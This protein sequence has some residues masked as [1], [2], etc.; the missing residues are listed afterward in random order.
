MLKKL[1][2][3]I[4]NKKS[5]SFKLIA[6][7][8]IATI[9]A[10]ALGFVRE[11][12]IA[13]KYGTSIYSDAFIASFSLP[14]LLVSGFG[15]AIS[16]L[17][18]PLYLKTI[19][20]N[21]VEGKKFN[22]TVSLL[23]MFIASILV[24]AFSIF[25][26]FFTKLFVSGFDDE[27]MK[28][29]VSLSR[30]MIFASFPMLLSQHYKAFS[31]IKKKYAWSMLFECI[32]NIIIIT[33]IFV[34]KEEWI[35][36]L[37]YATVAGYL[38]YSVVM[39]IFSYVNDFRYSKKTNFKSEYVKNLLIGVLPVLFANLI[40][41]INQIIDK[42]FASSLAIGTVSALNYSSKII[43]LVTA[44]IGTTIATVFFPSI[45]KKAINKDKVG[46]SKSV[47][48][49]NSGILFFIVPIML[50][51]LV[52]AKE[53]VTFLFKRGN[54]DDDS[55]TVTTN[56]L[57][58]YSASMIGA[59]LR[60]IWNRIF[61]AELNTRVPAINSA[62]SVAINVGLN[63][64]LITSLKERGIAL[65][66]SISSLFTAFIFIIVYKR[67]NKDY[68]IRTILLDFLKIFVGNI[69][70][71]SLFIVNYL[72]RLSIILNLLIGFLSFA[73]LFIVY[74]FLEKS[75][76]IWL[77]YKENDIQPEL[78]KNEEQVS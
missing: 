4:R 61:N 71:F 74:Y 35:V 42:N 50:F 52:Y 1:F 11:L 6:F 36:F 14:D 64:L 32:I 25:P 3:K 24:L 9:L 49:L 69:L 19:E 28:L 75:L 72:V 76:K 70:F 68:K 77:F 46:L 41:E 53:I 21:E 34:I 37:A 13:Y 17:Y 73:A 29:T 12:S 55:I 48:K 56:C 26:S 47:Y 7:V 40:L 15:A 63:F 5:S 65:A 23:L 43:N 38:I 31:Q 27:A 2:N 60:A 58:Y 39:L 54:F 10:R 59:N 51:V 20:K 78:E 16:T 22:T 44:L 66:T 57:V 45:S 62:L 33:A 18:I 30:I 67:V 8:M